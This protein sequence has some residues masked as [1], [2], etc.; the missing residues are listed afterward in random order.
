[1]TGSAETMA[2]AAAAADPADIWKESAHRGLSPC[3][4]YGFRYSAE[5]DS[6]YLVWISGNQSRALLQMSKHVTPSEGG[7][8]LDTEYA[9]YVCGGAIMFIRLAPTSDALVLEDEPEEILACRDELAADGLWTQAHPKYCELQARDVCELMSPNGRY[10]VVSVY[11]RMLDSYEQMLYYFPDGYSGWSARGDPAPRVGRFGI[12]LKTLCRIE[13]EDGGGQFLDDQLL[14]YTVH[15]V[16]SRY[17]LDGEGGF[18][19]EPAAAEQE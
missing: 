16:V 4:K 8:F 7:G 10:G 2:Q 14:E 13:S 19:R 9:W 12:A 11:S 5:R 17:R 3:G 1:M 15:G 6:V 18:R